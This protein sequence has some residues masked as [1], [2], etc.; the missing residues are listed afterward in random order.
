[1]SKTL[2]L[3]QANDAF[4]TQDDKDHQLIMELYQAHFSATEA[5]RL[6]QFLYHKVAEYYRVLKAIKIPR[7]DRFSLVP[8]ERRKDLQATLK[9]LNPDTATTIR[10]STSKPISKQQ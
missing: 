5:A 4:S 8:P 6:T 3:R 2:R 7:H 9:R 1:M 10:T